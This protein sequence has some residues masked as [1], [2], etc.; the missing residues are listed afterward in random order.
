MLNT[1]I[2][3]ID[4][5]MHL[6]NYM[7]FKYLLNAVARKIVTPKHPYYSRSYVINN[8]VVSADSYDDTP[9]DEVRPVDDPPSVATQVSAGERLRPMGT[10]PST[11][12]LSDAVVA[13][14]FVRSFA[15]A[16]DPVPA[17]SDPVPAASDPVPAAS[18]PS[19][20]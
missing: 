7:I 10:A 19:E 9:Y 13:Q 20:S 2:L 4:A 11:T 3:G 16:A 17:A 5:T 8:E 6:I 12:V 15:A 14:K 18:N 1:S